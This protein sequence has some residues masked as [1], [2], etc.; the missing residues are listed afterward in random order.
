MY[1]ELEGVHVDF[2]IKLTG[3]KA[4]RQG[5]GT[6]RSVAAARV[7]KEAGI[8]TLGTYIDKR[9]ATVAEWVAL[10]SILEI[11]DREK[12]YKVGGRR[13]GPWW[14]QTADQE[15]LSATLE[16]ILAASMARRW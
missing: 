3:Q 1:R 7:I 4:T 8:Q 13:R 14:R 5:G 10:R 16:D 9:Q 15:Q 6:W 12:V 2:L 11:C